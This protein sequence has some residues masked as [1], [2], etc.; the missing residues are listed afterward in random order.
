MPALI[1]QQ[2]FCGRNFSTDELLM[3]RDVVGICGGISRNELA[4]TVCE[5]LDWR[6]P[7]GR[8]KAR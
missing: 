7:R 5:L 4:H 6:R 3:I 8:L 1:K 2:R